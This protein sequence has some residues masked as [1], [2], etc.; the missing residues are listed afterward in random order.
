MTDLQ[1]VWFSWID[2]KF[3]LFCDCAS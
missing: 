3:R 2:L 1:R